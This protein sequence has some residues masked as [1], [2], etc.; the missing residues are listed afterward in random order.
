MDNQRIAIYVRVS[1]DM[2]GEESIENQIE[3]CKQ[4]LQFKGFKTDTA[5]VI[6]DIA[7]GADDGRKGLSQLMEKINNKEIDVLIVTELSRLS[8]KIK[9]LINIIEAVK[10]NDVV[11]I[12]VI[13]NID[14]ATPM[15]KAMIL[16]TGLFAEL[17]RDN[18]KQRVKNTMDT[19]ARNGNHTGGVAP[20]GYD[21]INKELVPNPEKSEIVK[22]LFNDFI[23]G[24]SLSDLSRNYAIRLTTVRRIL[25]SPT[26]IGT[27][28]YGTRIVNNDGKVVYADPENIK[29]IPNAHPPIVDEETFYTVQK[30]LNESVDK[31]HLRIKNK[32]KEYL[33]YG[34]LKCYNGHSMYGAESPSHYRHY[35][36]GLHGEK[37]DHEFCPKKNISATEIEKDVINDILNF[38]ISKVDIEKGKKLKEAELKRYSDNLRIEQEKVKKI[39]DLYVNDQLEKDDYLERKAVIDKKMKLLESKIIILTKNI[40]EDENQRKS[41]NSLKLV[42][43]K[44]KINPPFEKMQKYLHTIVNKVQFI[45]DFEY[46]IY[47]NI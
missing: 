29:Y 37:V 39:T 46:E 27:K 19:K 1:T 16:M 33:L 24:V 43:E 42:I 23:L 8:R 11:I 25:A 36:C 41:I 14:T 13:Q 47:F 2:Q 6:S 20:Y 3:R 4:Y 22:K 12:S 15:G 9:T 26:Y 30:L 21:V 10:S 35:K 40:T 5:E 32:Q 28:V 38:D 7:S 18:L 17:E 31:W 44:L 34:L 45:N